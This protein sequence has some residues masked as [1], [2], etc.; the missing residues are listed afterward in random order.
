MSDGTT[1]LLQPETVTHEKAGAREMAPVR[2]Q[3]LQIKQRFPDTIL[4][5][6]IGD[7][8]ETFEEDARDAAS[9]LDI[10]LTSR[11]MGKG[12]RVPLAGIPHHAAE[13]YIARL[14]AAGRKVAIC[15]QVGVAQRG[16]MERDVTRVVT[17]GTVTDPSMLDGQ[18]HTYIAAAVVEEQRGG[19]AYAELSTGVFAATQMRAANREEVE[20][21]VAR[22]ILRLG[23]A[24][25]ILSSDELHAAWIPEST[26]VSTTEPWRWRLER[27]RDLLCD[28]FGVSMLDG[29]GVE[30]LPCAIRAAGGLL[31]YVQDMQRSSLAQLT[32]LHH[33]STDGYMVLDAQARRNLELLESGRGER[34][35]SLIAVLDQTST[36]MGARL[37]RTWLNQP[38]LDPDAIRQRQQAVQWFC[39]NPV[40][41]ASF[42][43]AARRIGDIERLTNRALLVTI[44]PRELVAFRQ[45]LQA[46]SHIGP[47]DAGPAWSLPDASRAVCL[48]TAAFL[49]DALCDD[50]PAS[51]GAGGVIR[52]GF[53]PELDEH[54][55]NVREA[56]EWIA[57]LERSERERTG[58]RTLKV[59]YNRVSG[60]FIEITA[61]ALLARSRDNG[62]EDG[63]TSLPDDYLI[64]QSLANATRYVTAHLKECEARVL[65]AQ[66]TLAQLEADVF[67]RVVGFVAARRAPLLDAAASLARADVL[68]AFSETAATRGYTCPV[69]DDSVSLEIRGGRH[70][71]LEAILAPGTFVANDAVLDA[72]GAAITILTG[73]NMAGKSS[74][75]RQCGLIV[76]MA[77]VGSFVPADRARIGL[78][79]RIFSRIGA[80]DDIAAG[81]ST[82]MVE[83]LETANIVHHATRRS[84]VLLD[85]IGRGTST[86]DGLAIARAVVEHLHN[87]P[88]LGC[89]TLFATHFHELTVL[90]DYLPGVACARMDVLE[91]G[92]RVV[93]LHRV[94]PGGADR[95]Y[96]IHVAELAGLPRALTRRARE[97]LTDLEAGPAAPQ[98]RERRARSARP[99]PEAGAMQLTLFSP[100]SPAVEALQSLDVDSLSPLEALNRLYELKRLAGD[101]AQ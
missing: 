32:T 38:L 83:M 79:D 1:T 39:D 18:R 85:E 7:F 92:D 59:G 55:Q 73:P 22:E 64:R 86:W 51:V 88:G 23:A 94:V 46:L 60:Y 14:V 80:Q 48:E 69:V 75:L 11:E 72:E 81:Q 56:R 35:H 6:R 82:F 57:G 68:A 2:R 49:Q 58:I 89:R 71:T 91:E 74:V 4:L 97:I 63:P 8:Y 13:S 77:Q 9:L 98:A 93:F 40:A 61:N 66:E 45:S 41:R 5:F 62:S 25:V 44:T 12:T 65:G 27:T 24:E 96:G 29:F 42:R 52:P 36:P 100:P 34:R 26:T 31:A 99:V 95:S 16:L 10:T 28:H 54:E 15:E 50:V 20:A 53:A 101:G 21:A 47:D 19:V 70:P 90:A 43:E 33:Y 76:L 17:P 67:R 84:L 30:D 3:Y 37:L 87:A 78:V